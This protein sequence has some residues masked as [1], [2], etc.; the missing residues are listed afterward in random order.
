MESERAGHKWGEPTVRPHSPP[1]DSH[2]W[3]LC[4]H[5]TPLL[6]YGLDQWLEHGKGHF[7]NKATKHDDLHLAHTRSTLCSRTAGFDQAS[8]HVGQAYMARSW[9]QHS[10][11][12]QQRNEAH[13]QTT[14][15]ELKAANNR[16]CLESTLGSQAL[17]YSPHRHLDGSLWETPKPRTR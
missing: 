6:Q 2:L 15:E 17:R 5:I 12:I 3:Y 13:S 10:A 4:S 8:C 14:G 7:S 11:N 9:K 1:C 16:L